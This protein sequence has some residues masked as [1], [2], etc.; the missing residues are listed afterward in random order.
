MR[1]VVHWC[2]WEGGG[3]EHCSFSQSSESSIIEGLVIGTQSEGYAGR[4]LVRTDG[5]F[6]TR[7]VR[8]DF[9]G[10]PRLHLAADSNGNWHDLIS[11]E[12][13]PLLTGCL[14]VD[15]AITPATNTLPVRRLR[16]ARQTSEDIVVAYI[17][18]PAHT[19]S[20]F[21]PQVMTQRY[22]CL[23]PDQRYRYE[24]MPHGFTAELQVDEH[25][26]VLDY[27]QLF[28]RL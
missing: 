11:D 12:P 6:R 14:D 5:E 15:I 1:T 3:L 28:R 23:I 26:L 2:S 27:P 9:V 13:V 4:Y 25:G 8:V 17:P 24:S 19:T 10:G 22:T 7:E 21:V 20:D 18:V 16:L